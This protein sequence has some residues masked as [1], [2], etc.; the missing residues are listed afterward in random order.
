MNDDVKNDYD[1]CDDSNDNDNYDDPARFPVNRNKRRSRTG[2]MQWRQRV[3]VWYRHVSL[4]S[5][6]TG[7]IFVPNIRLS[8]EF[9]YQFVAEYFT[10]SLYNI[11]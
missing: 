10:G 9:F 2:K 8:S 4:H 5:S 3:T 7:F 1:W 6:I 11:L